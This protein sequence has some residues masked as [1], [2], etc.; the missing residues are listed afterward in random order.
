MSQQK[1]REYGE[2]FEKR[3]FGDLGLK[4]EDLFLPLLCPEEE[5]VHGQAVK[6]QFQWLDE[7]TTTGDIII[8]PFTLDGAVAQRH[9]KKSANSKMGGTKVETFAITRYK[10]PRGDKKYNHPQKWGSMPFIPPQLLNAYREKKKIKTLCVTEGYFKAIKAAQCGIHCIG[11]PSI[12]L[13]RDSDENDKSINTEGKVRTLFSAIYEIIEV[14]QVE[15]LCIVWDGDARNISKK[16]LSAH[17]NL[18]RR[19]M[20]FFNAAMALYYGTRSMDV[21]TYYCGIESTSMAAKPKG[22]DDLLIEAEKTSRVGEVVEAIESHAWKSPYFHKILI[23]GYGDELKE[24]LCPKDPD[25]FYELN[26]ELI[27]TEAWRLDKSVY[28]YDTIADS[29][30][31]ISIAGLPAGVDVLAYT[32]FGFFEMAGKYY[33]LGKGNSLEQLT[34]FTIKP[35][36]MV[37]SE[38]DT[39]RIWELTNESGRKRIFDISVKVLNTFTDFKTLLEG[40]GDFLCIKLSQDRLQLL[41]Y[42]LYQEE[43]QAIEIETLGYHPHGFWAWANCIVGEDGTIYKTDSMGMVEYGDRLYYLPYC[44][45]ANETN[46]NYR[47]E[48]CFIHTDGSKSSLREWSKLFLAAFAVNAP[49]AK[50]T[51]AFTMASLFRD[52]IMKNVQQMPHLYLQGKRG[53]G[54]SEIAKRAVRIFGE[55]KDPFN[56]ENSSTAK[57]LARIMSQRSNVALQLEE[58]SNACDPRIIGVLKS[59]ADGIGYTR[60][61]ASN[62]NRTI[63]TVVRATPIITGQDVPNV[64]PALTSRMFILQTKEANFEATRKDYEKL[65]DYEEAGLSN[66]VN[67]IF[68][69]RPKIIAQWKET[70]ATWL[71]VLR[72]EYRDKGI[73]ERQ[74]NFHAILLTVAQII[75]NE[76]KLPFNIKGE[77]SLQLALADVIKTG[78]DIMEEANEVKLFFEI[79]TIMM[80][81]RVIKEGL[82]YIVNDSKFL[83]VRMGTVYAYYCQERGRVTNRADR[84]KG[85]L[86]TY[87]TADKSFIMKDEKYFFVPKMKTS[88]LGFDILS[89]STQYGVEILASMPCDEAAIQ[90]TDNKDVSTVNTQPETKEYDDTLPF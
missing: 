83:W 44:T 13:I 74:L 6:R 82:D 56:F 17:R 19:P 86:F 10:E 18:R 89:L 75:N 2:Y 59:I 42:K 41:K 72:V 61:V 30:I 12:T 77:G 52:V 81:K 88:V 73:I 4:P 16:D 71:R 8:T 69:C 36:F 60:A 66:V 70:F 80:Q 40:S 51:L 54:K 50:I 20:G 76:I 68:A 38:T 64:D 23:L 31:A 84:G 67:D 43:K 24:H 58:F 78:T 34:N 48:H 79:F 32:K 26:K 28:R 14:C 46:P 39:K 1:P 11:L 3:V 15:Y 35:L 7:K 62:D 90:T 53:T 63:S 47:D 5:D 21:L 57:S 37:T 25:N 55:I 9:V 29:L 33:S 87:F 22:L 85:T 45:A 27:G 49:T 65:L